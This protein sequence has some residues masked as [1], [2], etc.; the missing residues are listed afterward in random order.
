MPSI[1]I[2]GYQRHPESISVTL[3]IANQN[4]SIS[5]TFEFRNAD[6]VTFRVLKDMAVVEFDLEKIR[7]DEARRQERLLIRRAA[8]LQN[9]VGQDIDPIPNQTFEDV[10]ATK[11]A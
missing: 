2:A 7:R 4:F 10:F 8:A 6:D 9:F 3:D 11:V 5:R 1:V